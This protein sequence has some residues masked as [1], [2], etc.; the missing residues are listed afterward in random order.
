MKLIPLLFFIAGCMQSIVFIWILP[1]PFGVIIA[2]FGGM[3]IGIQTVK[4]EYLENE[5]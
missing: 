5:I 4:L 3:F 2:I 1:E